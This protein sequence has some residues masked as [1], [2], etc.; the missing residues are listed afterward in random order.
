[1]KIYLGDVNNKDT[2][3]SDV[4]KYHFLSLPL[5]QSLLNNQGVLLDDRTMEGN[6]LNLIKIY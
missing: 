6:N 1:M 2:I 5:Y 3:S 4:T